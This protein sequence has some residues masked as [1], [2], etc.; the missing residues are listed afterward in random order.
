MSNIYTKSNTKHVV[1]HTVGEKRF[2]S[3]TKPGA[4][5]IWSESIGLVSPVFSYLGFEVVGLGVP[6]QKIET[7]NTELLIY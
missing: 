2:S 1:V 5:T 3:K 6:Q 4:N 7:A